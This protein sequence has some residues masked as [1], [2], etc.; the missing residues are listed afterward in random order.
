MIPKK[1]Q[2]VVQFLPSCISRRTF[3]ENTILK[4]ESSKYSYDTI[5]KC[6]E[7]PLASANFQNG[8]GPFYFTHGLIN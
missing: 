1:T 6:Y 7:I 2:N 3:S 8:K 4:M 5:T